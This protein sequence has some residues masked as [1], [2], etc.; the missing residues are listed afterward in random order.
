MLCFMR[1]SII[2]SFITRC[3]NVGCTLHSSVNCNKIL[4]LEII[5]IE[6][7][8]KYE[9]NIDIIYIRAHIELHKTHN[10]T[11]SFGVP[12]RYQTAY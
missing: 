10:F 9:E 8:I 12:L 2:L 7:T 1:I 11:T 5:Q 4:E 3:H 6:S